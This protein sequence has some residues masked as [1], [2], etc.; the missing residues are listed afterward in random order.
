MGQRGRGDGFPSLP[1]FSASFHEDER[2]LDGLPAPDSFQFSPLTHDDPFEVDYQ[3]PSIPFDAFAVNMPGETIP[4]FESTPPS[5]SPARFAAELR[6]ARLPN[7]NQGGTGPLAGAIGAGSGESSGEGSGKGDGVGDENGDGVGAIQ[8]YNPR[9]AYPREARR[10]SIEGVVVVELSIRS[11]G[12][13][14]VNKVLESSGSRVLDEAVV[15]TVATWKYRPA[16]EAG[17]PVTSVERIRFV[18]QLAK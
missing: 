10:Q 13:C 1:A 5:E 18:F 7:P 6:G 4:V 2:R 14:S 16:T 15:A 3:M 17:R 12:S 11:D 8:I 9:P